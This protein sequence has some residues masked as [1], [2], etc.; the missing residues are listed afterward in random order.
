MES[1]AAARNG[2]TKTKNRRDQNEFNDLAN[3]LGAV[4]NFL[5]RCG[6]KHTLP[7]PTHVGLNDHRAYYTVGSV[8]PQA[9]HAAT[10]VP[11]HKSNGYNRPRSARKYRGRIVDR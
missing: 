1:Q 8:D 3:L 7:R 2:T 10:N 9:N 4:A 6:R 11:R 5:L